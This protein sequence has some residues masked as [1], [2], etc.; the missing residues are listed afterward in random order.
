MRITYGYKVTK[1]NDP[2]ITVSDEAL[3][4]LAS[5]AVAGS[6]LVDSYPFIRHLPTWLPGMGF[7]V[8]AQEWS[9]LPL[10]MI[11]EPYK[12]ARK[13]IVSYHYTYPN[14]CSFMCLERGPSYPF[15]SFRATGAKRGWRAR[16]RYY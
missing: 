9:K 12:W 14:L 11:E 16:G 1:A 5:S 7:K 2:Y 15:V 3:A 4:T 8:Q 13:Q 6:Y 10:R